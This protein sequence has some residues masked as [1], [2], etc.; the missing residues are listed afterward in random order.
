MQ[1]MTRLATALGREGAPLRLC[2]IGSAACLFGGMEG[3]TSVDLDVWKPASSYDR[4]ELQRAAEA[5]GL[6]F[7]PKSV[8]DPE[9]PYLQIIEPGLVEVGEFVPVLIDRLGR[10]QLF[11]PP[12]EN[13]IAA[14]LLR[15]DP[16]DLADIR[17]LIGLHRPDAARVR[18]IVRA[19]SAAARN[20]AEENLVYLE[21]FAP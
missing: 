12:V 16:K 14:K 6:Q 15:A 2:L 3:R 10:L 20:R 21:V 13:L 17:F 5:A 18:E 7:D 4:I 19:F 9:A 8:L 1:A 11:R